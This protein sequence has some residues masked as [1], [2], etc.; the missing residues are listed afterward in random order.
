MDSLRTGV[1]Q[2]IDDTPNDY[3]NWAPGEPSNDTVD[4]PC[5]IMYGLFPKVR[6]TLGAKWAKRSCHQLNGVMCELN[7]QDT[8]T[9]TSPAPGSTP[10][11]SS[12]A[13]RAQV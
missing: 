2:W 8:T 7:M 1:N 4:A 11:N 10:G 9:N 6:S 13:P 5:T 12:V 3:Y